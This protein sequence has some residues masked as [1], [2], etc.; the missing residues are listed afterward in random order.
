MSIETT[1]DSLG[2][3]YDNALSKT[4]NDLLLRAGLIPRKR[5]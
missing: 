5:P 3:S 4:V 1:V 2:D